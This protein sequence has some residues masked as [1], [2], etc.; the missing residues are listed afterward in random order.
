MSDVL[1]ECREIGKVF[2]GVRALDS[3]GLRLTAG[4]VHAL[5][6]ENGAGKSTLIKV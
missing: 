6:G 1:L 5:L 3:V 2:P 4:S